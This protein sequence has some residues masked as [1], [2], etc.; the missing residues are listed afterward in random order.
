[1]THPSDATSPPERLLEGIVVCDF[2][3]VLSGPYCTRLLAD[4]GADVIKIERPG[5]GDE[6]RHIAPQMSPTAS[7]Q[8]AYFARINAGKRSIAIDFTNPQARD[9]VLDLVRKADVVVEN[10]SPGVMA[11]YRF[12]EPSLRAIKP[13]LVYCSISGFGQTGPL[14]GLQAYAHLINA[15]SGMMDLDRSGFLA[16]KASNLQAADVLAGAHAFGAICAALI[17][18][19]RRGQGAYLDVSMLECLICADDVNF[20]ALLNDTPIER[21]P[22]VGMVV[23][24]IGGRHVA[25]QVGGA[26]NMWA[27]MVEAMKRPDLI[28]DQRFAT[29]AARRANWGELMTL[30]ADWLGTMKSADEAL[31]TLG[32]SRV[33]AVPMMMAEEIVVHPH[34]AHRKAFP[35]LSH[36]QRP[37]GV[38]VTAAPFQLDGEA[39]VPQA[40]APWRIGEHTREVLGSVLGYD[41]A[42]IA[43]LQAGGV[44][45]SAD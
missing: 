34:L 12:D 13:D 27:R 19:I 39:V 24:E 4:L 30:I 37:Q 18:Q 21:K 43:A 28:N 8:G 10:F 1:M 16:P 7:D 44:V 14:R 2:T 33:P 45:K 17:R 32:A 42:R 25:M 6:V 40:T 11:K 22:R 35:V 23:Q 26:A 41:A 29:T 3:R 9:V 36:P 15:F 5:E 38:R 31:D 20:P